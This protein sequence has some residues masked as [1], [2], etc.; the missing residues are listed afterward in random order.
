MTEEGH[1]VTHFTDIANILMCWKQP[2]HPVHSLVPDPDRIQLRVRPG[3]KTHFRLAITCK[4]TYQK[5]FWMNT[6][7]L[8]WTEIRDALRNMVSRVLAGQ[9][10][11]FVSHGR[12][13]YL[14]EGK[15][16]TRTQRLRNTPY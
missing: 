16:G 7:Y 15:R 6:N 13:Y 5:A 9:L 14:C 4:D 2:E 3:Y 1:Q 12:F 11:I 8:R 10:P